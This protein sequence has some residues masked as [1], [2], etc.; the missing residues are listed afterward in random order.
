M[1][2]SLS[3][4]FIVALALNGI[5]NKLKIPGLLGM[6]FTGILLGP[7]V[8]NLISPEILAVSSDLREIALIVILLRAGFSLD[9]KDL[10]RVGRP[11]ILLCFIPATFEIVAIILLA[12]IFFGM[13]TLEA[14]ILATVVAAVSPAVVVPRMIH[15]LDNGYVK[16]HSVPQLIMAGASVDDVFVIVLFTS[17]MGMYKGD[18][19]SPTSLLKVPVSIILGIGLGYVVGLVLIKLFERIHMRDTVKI[20]VIFA[21][22]FLLV[23]MQTAVESYI[24]IS[25]LLAIMAIGVTILMRYEKLAFRLKNKFSKIWV[26]AELILF[27]LV[28]AAVDITYLQQAG[29]LSVLLILLALVF[30][31]VGVMLSLVKS[32]LNKKERL[33]SSIAYLPKATVQAAIGSIPLSQGVEAGNMILLIAVLAILVTAPIGA[34]GID[35]TYDKLL[36]KEG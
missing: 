21:T 14:A 31:M 28:G 27:V 16:K 7:Y 19:F 15:L 29:L 17:F 8:L 25:G 4:I 10:K 22:S 18:G 32:P 6:I 26:F 36:K 30:R 11:A 33:F 1:L 35:L 2:L 23:S 13:T 5:L 20:L 24:P 34:I 12:P 3:L 9:L